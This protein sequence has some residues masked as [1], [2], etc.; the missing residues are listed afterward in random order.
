[1]SKFFL[2]L[3]LAV[4]WAKNSTH[5]VWPPH[6]KCG[7]KKFFFQKKSSELP[8]HPDLKN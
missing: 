5:A 4:K 6:A 8:K 1:M 2:T 7:E 3:G